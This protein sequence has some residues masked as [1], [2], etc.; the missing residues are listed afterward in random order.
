MGADGELGILWPQ[1]NSS[2]TSDPYMP[3]TDTTSAVYQRGTV[4]TGPLSSGGDAGD[5]ISNHFIDL[6]TK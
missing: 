3:I 2:F 5:N 6:S 1:S 4:A